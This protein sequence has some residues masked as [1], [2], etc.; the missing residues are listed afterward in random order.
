MNVEFLEKEKAFLTIL[1]N[2]GETIFDQLATIQLPNCNY[3][4]FNWND[5]YGLKE[6]LEQLIEINGYIQIEREDWDDENSIK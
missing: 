4:Y 5:W 3:E 2:M 1:L 6:K